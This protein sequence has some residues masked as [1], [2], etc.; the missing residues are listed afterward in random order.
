MGS[1]KAETCFLRTIGAARCEGLVV[2]AVTRV[3]GGSLQYM[4]VVGNGSNWLCN[5]GSMHAS[6]RSRKVLAGACSS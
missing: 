1:V 2:W 3:I 5:A 6:P 4:L